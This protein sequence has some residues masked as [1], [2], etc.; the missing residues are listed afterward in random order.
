MS[1]LIAPLIVAG[2]TTALAIVIT[3][4]DA[5]VNNY[6]EVE[7]DINNGKRILKVRGGAPLLTTLSSEG[8]FVPSACGGRGSCGA[9]KVKILSDVG[10]YLPT[11]IPYMSKEEIAKNVR[12]SCQIKVKKPIKIELPEELFNIR[13]FKGI[14][15]SLKDVTY[16]IKE[17]RIRLIEPSEISFKAGQYAQLIIPPYENI[18]EPTQRAYSIS[19]PPSEKERVEF[20]IRLV[21]GGIATTYVHKYLKEG[22]AI[23]LVGPFGDF[24]VRDTEADMIMVAGG[25]GMAPIKSMLLDMYE[26]G[27]THRRVWY[28]FGARSG[29]DLYYV[30]LFRELEKH[31]PNFKFIPALSEPR[32]EDSWNGE[33]GLITAV[34]ERYLQSVIPR[35]N[36]KEGYLC[37]SPGMINA[38][39]QV[40]EKFGIKDVYYDKFA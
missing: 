29:R 11:E 13:K 24:Y 22:D 35:D 5:I 32:P 16:D 7:I 4:V 18:K 28:F 8:I 20:L 19:S 1:V 9:C 38:C 12:L 31:W 26:R 37:G 14:V 3:I 27:I 33:V 6:G 25:S 36:S 21:P 2:L 17:V 15:E 34:L 40:F 10:P 23:E 30:E 39:I